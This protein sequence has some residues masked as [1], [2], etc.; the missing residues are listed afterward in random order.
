MCKLLNT[1]FRLKNKKINP[2]TWSR[3]DRE[4]KLCVFFL[5][6]GSVRPR[7]RQIKSSYWGSVGCP[8]FSSSLGN[9][10]GY[11][12]TD[13]FQR[14]LG[15]C[16]ER[17]IWRGVDIDKVLARHDPTIDD[18]VF[19]VFHEIAKIVTILEMSHHS[20]CRLVFYQNW[21]LIKHLL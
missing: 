21:G 9:P 15:M 14:L 2:G 20:N 10:S 12:C 17:D 18:C 11:P 3:F 16:L 4:S 7:N 1:L 19:G 5:V 8:R 13:I 6:F